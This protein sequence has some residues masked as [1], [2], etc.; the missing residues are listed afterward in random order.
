M[1]AELTEIDNTNVMYVRTKA[2]KLIQS[3]AQESYQPAWYQ[4]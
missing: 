3:S 2:E 1:I 4:T